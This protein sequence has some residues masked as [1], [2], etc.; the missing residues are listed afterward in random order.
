MT[1]KS[2]PGEDG[3]TE[4]PGPAR[5]RRRNVVLTPEDLQPWSTALEV[6]KTRTP[7]PTLYHYTTTAGLVGIVG[8]QSLRLSH[9]RFLNDRTEMV[10]A[11]RLIAEILEERRSGANERVAPFLAEVAALL[12]DMFIG[13]DPFVACFC[14]GG[15][16]LSQWRGYSKGG[17]MYALGFS[18]DALRTDPRFVL[19]PIIYDVAEQKRLVSET[20]AKGVNRHLVPFRME[21]PET[22][23]GIL[24][25]P[26]TLAMALS[27]WFTIFKDVSFEEE[28]EWRISLLHRGTG[29]EVP[30]SFRGDHLWYPVPFTELTFER[31][32]FPLVEVKC[33]PCS[34]PKLPTRA[35]EMLLAARGLSTVE[36]SQSDI[37]LRW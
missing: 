10:Y 1:M 15:D 11:Q 7:P 27:L 29:E 17:G 14:H 5:P 21:G 16:L 6:L 37:P 20:I 12:P 18:S 30:I 19:L 35:V 4:V 32:G 25:P 3:E 23:E 8:N 28:R 36:V 13:V 34:E 9:V 24:K 22:D 26:Q 33:G 2:E 31:T